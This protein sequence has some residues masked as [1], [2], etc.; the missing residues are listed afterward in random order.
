MWSD[1]GGEGGM[2]EGQLQNYHQVAL[3]LADSNKSLGKL[4]STFLFEIQ[5]EEKKTKKNKERPETGRTNCRWRSRRW[6][7]TLKP[8]V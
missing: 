1:G 7:F 2:G 8:V 3:K 6:F 4:Q 5:F